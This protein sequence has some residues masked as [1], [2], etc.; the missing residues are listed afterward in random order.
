MIEIL[1]WTTLAA[2]AAAALWRIPSFRKKK[3]RSLFYIFALLTLAILLSIKGPYAAIDGLLGGMNVANLLL[4]FII[5]AAIY[6]LGIRIATG[7]GD[8]GGLTLIRGRSGVLVL[9]LIS[10]AL[11]ILFA[12][13]DTEGSSA[14][15][16][17][18]GG[19]DER[20]A[21]LVEFYGAAGRAYPAYI[22]LAI[23]PG[24]MRAVGST[25]PVPLRISALLMAVGAIAIPLSLL[26]PVIPP[27]L[28]F[29]PFIINYTAILCF[30]GG[31]MLVWVAKGRAARKQPAGR[32]HPVAG[33]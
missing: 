16:I 33:N 25:L 28:G 22:C 21:A 27:A 12:L 13:M 7:F 4:R 30:V 3:N 1:Q 32:R 23:L 24:L 11:V 9:G 2:C 20:N 5:F 18:V 8:N 10:V 14:G 26:F 29:L 31:F 19:K 17:A 15:M 6:F